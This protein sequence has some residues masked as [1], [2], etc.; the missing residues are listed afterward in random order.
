MITMVMIMV[1]IQSGY[2]TA[3]ISRC[4]P[5]FFWDPASILGQIQVWMAPSL[6]ISLGHLSWLS[7]NFMR[8]IKKASVQ[9]SQIVLDIFVAC[10]KLYDI[11]YMVVAA[12]ISQIHRLYSSNELTYPHTTVGFLIGDPDSFKH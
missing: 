12:F 1:M 6:W 2:F 7:C 5:I 10:M 11:R 4:I 3:D 9:L 8:A